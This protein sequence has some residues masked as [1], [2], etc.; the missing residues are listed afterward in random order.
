MKRL[1]SKN[2]NAKIIFMQN[3]EMFCVDFILFATY[4][5]YI[6]KINFDSEIFK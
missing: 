6:S 5:E 2:C 4:A 3:K 1:G